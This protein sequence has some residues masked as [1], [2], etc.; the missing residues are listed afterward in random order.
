MNAIKYKGK[1]EIKSTLGAVIQS[2]PQ[3]F[4][5]KIAEIRPIIDST[6]KQVNDMTLEE[7]KERLFEIDPDS[8]QEPQKKKKEIKI[9]LPNLDRFKEVTLRLAPYPSG[10]LHIGNTRMVVL[11]DYLAK[12]YKG[13]LYLVFDDTIGSKT[14]IID[15][16]AYDSIPEGLDYLDVKV[17]KTYYKSDRLDLFY[18]YALQIITKG[19]AYVCTCDGVTW[20]TT[21][22]EDKT[23]CPCRSRTIEDNLD[24]W[25]KMLDGTYPELGAV[26]RLKTEMDAPDPAIRD[27]VML[28]ISEREHP[29]VGSKYRVWPLL[30]F[31]WGIDDHELNIS[32]I[33]RG[34]DLRKEGVLE[35]RIWDV[36]QW[37]KPTI[38][39]YGRMKLYD[40]QLSKSESAQK[41]R[42]GEYSDWTDPRTG[43]CNHFSEEELSL[44]LFVSPY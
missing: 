28:R 25:E 5:S 40:L 41:I 13:K 11:N 19:S 30:E 24:H 14:K 18:D 36:F 4:K 34:K 16:D 33:I 8:L 32:H 7:Q 3:F 2:D 17:H 9:E 39:L 38:T 42:S 22:K 43:A 23:A 15:P 12:K 21:F 20:R 27:P 26:V 1:A 29:R 6:V 35:E 31:S 10:P 37:K 44:K